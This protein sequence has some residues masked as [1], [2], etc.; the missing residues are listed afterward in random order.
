MSRIVLTSIIVIVLACGFI[1]RVAQA[2]TAA[3]EANKKAVIEF[4]D[5]AINQKDFEAASKYFGPRYIQH[6]P[7]A[8]DGIEGFRGFLAFLR[9]KFP[10]AHS[11]IKRAFATG[12]YVILHVHAVREPG[13]RGAAIVDIFRLENGKVVEHWDVRQDIPEKAA[14]D[15][16]MF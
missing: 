8:P 6:N 14:N 16:G 12:D 1:G 5:K 9:E 13:T 7:T 11:E 2:E 4:Y 10:N 15:N 3:E